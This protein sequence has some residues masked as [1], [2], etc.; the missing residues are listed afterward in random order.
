MLGDANGQYN[1]GRSYFHGLGV[2]LDMEQ[3]KYW[4]KKAAAQGHKNATAFMEDNQ[5]I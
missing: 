5:W 3:A 2:P 1:L 4:V